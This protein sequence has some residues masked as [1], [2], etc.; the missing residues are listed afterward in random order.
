M[1]DSPSAPLN[2][3]A[4][5]DEL[6]RTALQ[7]GFSSVGICPAIEPPGWPNFL[8]WLELGFAGEMRYLPDRRDAY[9]HPSH[10]LDNARSLV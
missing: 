7:L 4:V 5:T 1:P 10:V 9:Q 8:Q 2:P 6:R 3:T